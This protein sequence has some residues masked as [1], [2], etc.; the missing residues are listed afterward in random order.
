MLVS[1]LAFPK[2]PRYPSNATSVAFFGYYKT[3]RNELLY[4]F[5]FVS[6]ERNSTIFKS[7]N[8]SSCV[9]L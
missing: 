9:Q 3:L 5:F 6:F 1:P 8:T 7:T 4:S 2:L